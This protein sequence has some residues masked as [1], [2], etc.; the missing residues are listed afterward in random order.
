MI[1]EQSSQR[2]FL[3]FPLLLSLGG[4]TYFTY[5]LE[6]TEFALLMGVYSG[7]FL[8]FWHLL[9]LGKTSFSL[10]LLCGLLFRIIQVWGLPNLSQDFYRFIWDGELIRLGI[11]PYL[12]T[13]DML[14]GHLRNT[15]PGASLLYDGMGSLSASHYSNYPPLNQFFFYLAAWLGGS[16]L[17]G[18]VAVLKVIIILSDL[19]IVWIGSRILT[20][21]K[22]PK[23]LILLYFLN[24]F[25]I[26]ELT[27]NLHFE[28]VMMFFFLAGL[29]TLYR[30]WWLV[31][32]ALIAASVS[33]K[34]I[35][36]IFL[37]LLFMYRSEL[38]LWPPSR[39]FFSAMGFIIA[40]LLLFAASF[41]P[42]Y[43]YNNLEHFGSSVNLWFSSFEFNASLYYLARQVGYW[44]KGYNTIGSI[45]PWIPVITLLTVAFLSFWKRNK[46]AGGVILSMLWA[47]SIYLFISTTVHPWYLIT[48]LLLSVFSGK[49]YVVA[50]SALV[51]L[52]YNTYSQEPYT[53]ST[54]FL[55]IEYGIV[56]LVFLREMILDRKI[57]AFSG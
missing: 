17:I 44:Y 31:A 29:Y 9:R 48:P 52:S 13:P 34:L 43:S 47:I 28:G 45:A 10:L 41:L 57:K 18:K 33:V 40:I 19:G 54:L 4:Y 21:L 55:F 14:Y 42:F 30:G 25:V 23:E 46:T 11:D 24:P 39:S 16:T 3:A 51:M 32:A 49:I 6:R 22:K 50:W 2:L 35:T 56:F 1:P 53:E 20:Y 37:P 7:L 26:I 27:G 5:Y 12:Q 36:L 8:L 15:L 38:K